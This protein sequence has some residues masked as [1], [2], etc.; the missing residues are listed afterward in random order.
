MATALQLKPGRLILV[1]FP[2]TD[3]G[4]TKVRPALVLAR[5]ALHVGG[6][7]VAVPISS[8]VHRPGYTLP[9][10]S[11]Y[12]AQTLLRQSSLVLWYKP[13]TIN[14]TLVQRLLG[15]IPDVVLKEIRDLTKSMFGTP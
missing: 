3:A 9:S 13:M 15:T 1:A 6:D 4:T 8:Q 12:F 11:P 14:E 7:F 2:F 5:H 10:Q